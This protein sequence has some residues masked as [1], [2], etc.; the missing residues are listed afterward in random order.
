VHQ[1]SFVQDFLKLCLITPR[2]LAPR[3]AL[4]SRDLLVWLAFLGIP[5]VVS[6][7][8]VKML[9]VVALL[10]IV[11]LGEMII[12]LVL[13]VSPPCHHVVQFHGSSRMIASRVVVGVLREEDVLEAVDDVL[14]SDVGDGGSY[15]EE[16]PV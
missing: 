1:A 11:V 14:I 15:L 7:A 3:I 16:T 10:V 6:L 8:L 9:V 2:L 5:R 12:L 4:N 13:P